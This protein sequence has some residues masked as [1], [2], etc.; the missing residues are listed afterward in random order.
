MLLPHFSFSA[1]PLIADVDNDAIEDL[2]L[3]STNGSIVSVRMGEFGEYLGDEQVTSLF[4]F[5]SFIFSSLFVDCCSDTESQEGLVR[6][7]VGC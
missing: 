1:S 3:V 6:R 7:F 5:L 4:H 2:I